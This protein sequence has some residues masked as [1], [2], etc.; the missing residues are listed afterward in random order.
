MGDELR[1]DLGP[2]VTEPE[3]RRAAAKFIARR[4]AAQ[5]PHLTPAE[6]RA[7][8]QITAG[9]RELFAALGL[10]DKEQQ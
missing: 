4:I 3:D 5:H 9:L 6:L 2:V 1:T 7:D 8:P 10:N